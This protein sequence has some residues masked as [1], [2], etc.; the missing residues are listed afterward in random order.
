LDQVLLNQVLAARMA[1][2]SPI[3]GKSV[4][5]AAIVPGIAHV[6]SPVPRLV[7]LEMVESLRSASR[8]RSIVSVV[9]IKAVVHVTIKAARSV[10]PWAGSD[11]YSTDEPVWAVVA[12][13]S[14]I[15]RS[16]IE[17]PVGAYR[18]HTN[19][20]TDGDL[21]WRSGRKA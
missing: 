10:K 20:D 16:V 14:A 6:A 13:G 15:V 17:I 11:K 3:A 18:R 5:T 4:L 9:R 1:S 21:G 7:S 19:V 8:Q 2:A 12:I